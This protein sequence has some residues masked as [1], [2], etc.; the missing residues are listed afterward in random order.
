MTKELVEEATGRPPKEQEVIK[1]A[2]K[3]IERIASSKRTIEEYRNR[4]ENEEITLRSYERQLEL[5]K[6]GKYKFQECERYYSKTGF[7]IEYPEP[8]EEE[9]KKS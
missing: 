4:K 3:V 1:E 6:Q 7:T 8:K 9:K 5:L 2:K